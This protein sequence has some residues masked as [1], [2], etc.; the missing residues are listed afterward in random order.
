VIKN[1]ETIKKV[2]RVALYIRVSTEEQAKHGYS[3][4]SQLARLKEYCK[5]K[6]Y[7]IVET[8]TDEGK[9]AR[10]KLKLRTELLRLIED[11]KIGKIDRIVFWRLDRWFRNIADYYKVQ[12]ILEANN[13]DWEC[14]DEEY[15]T[16]TSNG[17]LHLNI[18][19]S[20]A[21]NESDQTSDR[22]KFNFENMIKN[23]KA[24]CCTHSCAFGYKVEGEK[25]NKHVVKDEEKEEMVNFIFDTYE[26]T[27]NYRKTTI[28]F[29]E[30]Y[31]YSTDPTIIKK[32]LKKTIYYGEYKGVANYTEPY[33]TK[34]RFE[35]IQD[36]LPN[37]IK[38]NKNH[39]YIFCGLVICK[40]CGRKMSGS[41]NR[42][43]QRYVCKKNKEA[44]I[45]PNTKQITQNKLEKYLLL[46]IKELK[47]IE[48]NSMAK[49]TNELNIINFEKEI[50][51]INK[52]IDRLNELYIE[53]NISKDKYDKNIVSF[54][55]KKKLLLSQSKKRKKQKE[56]INLPDNTI[57]FYKML[58]AENKRN[59]WKKYIEYIEFDYTKDKLEERLKIILRWGTNCVVLGGLAGGALGYGVANNNFLSNNYNNQPV[60]YPIFYP[61]PAP[62]PMPY[63]YY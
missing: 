18:K 16:T 43:Y 6:K 56:I 48:I 42:G 12:E 27:N 63:P 11:I 5:Q 61:A 37:N 33:I 58:N 10:S 3:L 4:G 2:V 52:K 59:F 15:N 1:N 34:E 29:N 60:P 9:S 22:I 25:G 45:C 19:L 57:E 54:K 62:Y 24:I 32:M 38:K 20:I 55:D 35:K 46:I 28:L 39:D 23:K 44:K 50:I 49:D 36:M 7:K 40:Y 41:T 14:S 31:N 51:K 21:Q 47:E 30:K 13:V 53:G 17:R 8:Y 26:R